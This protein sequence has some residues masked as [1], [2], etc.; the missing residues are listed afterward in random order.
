MTERLIK[1]RRRAIEVTSRWTVEAMEE[2]IAAMIEAKILEA[3]ERM[4]AKAEPSDEAHFPRY[5]LG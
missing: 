4:K 1:A 3:A 2:F 5:P